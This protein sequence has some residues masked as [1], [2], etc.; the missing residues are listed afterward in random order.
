M[1]KVTIT[2]VQSLLDP[3]TSSLYELRFPTM[4]G[5]ANSADGVRQLRIACQ[6]CSLPAKTTEAVDVEVHAH[7]LHYTGKVTYS[8][9]LSI[10]FVENRKMSIY[11]YLYDWQAYSKNHTN[12]LGE[13]KEQYAKPAELRVFDQKQAVV[14]A[15]KLFGFWI[16]EI[17]E[18]TFNSDEAVVTLGCTFKYDYFER[19]AEGTSAA[20]P[21]SGA[22]TA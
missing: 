20:H 14:G 13:F 2:E 1:P 11:N 12:Q 17:P 4:A 10:T 5:V 21:A 8:G 3:L 7:M 19:F 18:V 22:V 16:S 9:D 15:Y 6:E